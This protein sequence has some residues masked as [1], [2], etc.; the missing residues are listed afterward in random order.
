MYVNKSPQDHTGNL[1]ASGG[2]AM[3]IMRSL[4]QAYGSHWP[5]SRVWALITCDSAVKVNGHSSPHSFL[6]WHPAGES[7]DIEWYKYPS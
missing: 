1:N 7:S 5:R 4:C 3:V 2:L 6:T